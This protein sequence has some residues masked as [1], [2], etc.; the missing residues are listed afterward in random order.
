MEKIYGTTI[1]QDG[2]QKIGRNKWLLFYGLYEGEN[3]NYEY[4]HTFNHKPT[5]EEVKAELVEA[6]NEQTREV[7]INGFEWNGQKIWLSEQVQLNLA[8]I[9]R[10]NFPAG[11][12][13]IGIKVNEDAE[14]DAIY[15]SFGS[16]EEFAEFHRRASEHIVA[17]L[18]M[19]WK[20]KKSLDKATYGY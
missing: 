20:E 2:L 4:R 18:D 17:A 16:A 15:M 11:Q 9:E 1:R 5:W 7:I 6:I 3:S 14:G 8:S 12:Y 13:P 10:A 19:G